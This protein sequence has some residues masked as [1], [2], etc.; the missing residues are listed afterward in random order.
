MAV[1]FEVDFVVGL[2]PTRAYR[3]IRRAVSTL[4]CS[5]GTARQGWEARVLI[6]RSAW[7]LWL[8]YFRIILSFIRPMFVRLNN[9]I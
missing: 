8:F 1:H 9:R 7:P 6:L 4:S 3:S 5:T 2:S